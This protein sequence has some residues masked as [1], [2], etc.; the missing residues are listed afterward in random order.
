MDVKTNFLYDDNV[1]ERS[2]RLI[3]NDVLGIRYLK[4]YWSTYTSKAKGRWVGRKVAEVFQEE[5]LAHNP[6]YAVRF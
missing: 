2:S 6:N 1:S 4:P 5:F 3:M